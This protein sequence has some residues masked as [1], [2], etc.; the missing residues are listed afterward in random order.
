MKNLGKGACIQSAQRYVNGI[1]TA[2]QD[3]DLEYDPKDLKK[4]VEFMKKTTKMLYMASRGLKKINLKI[5]K[6]L[7]I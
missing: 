3:A 7:L 5:P 4:I 1:L 6:T 2:I